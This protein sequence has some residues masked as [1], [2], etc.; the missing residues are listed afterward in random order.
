LVGYGQRAISA[1][2]LPAL[3]DL[4]WRGV[5]LSVVQRSLLN[6][7]FEPPL[8]IL[9]EKD[10]VAKFS[11]PTPISGNM[12]WRGSWVSPDQGAALRR[13]GSVDPNADLPAAPNYLL[14]EHTVIDIDGFFLRN[15]V[16]RDSHIIYKGAPIDM[17]GTYFVRCTFD[18]PALSEN[19]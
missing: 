19:S 15:V 13:L 14:I 3:H 6:S 16:F 10:W 8:P 12:Y 1:S 7:D 4:A 9:M 18:I 11:T 5:G 17:Q 2:H